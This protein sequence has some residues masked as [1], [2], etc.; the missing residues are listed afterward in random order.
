MNTLFSGRFA[1][2]RL[3]YLVFIGVSVLVRSL[4]LIKSWTLA[5][6]GIVALLK[7]FGMGLVFDI[8]AAAYMSIPLMLYLILLPE[9][10]YRQRWQR[11][12]LYIGFLA[13]FYLLG[14]MA[15][16]EWLFWDE[17]DSRFNFIAVDYLVYTHEVIG[18]IRESYPVVPLL[19]GVAVMALLGLWST[20]KDLVAALAAQSRWR[21]RLKQGG[22][23]ALIPLLALVAVDI[24]LAGVMTNRYNSELA[25][26][27]MYA[28]FAAYRNNELDY[29]RF[30]RSEDD[31]Q[32]T[33]RLQKL[34]QEPG[35][36]VVKGQAL[37]RHVQ[38]SGAEKH[39]NVVLITVES[40]SAEYLGMFGNTD[41]VSPHLDAL[42][43]DSLF[44]TRFYATGTRTVR[45][46]EAITLSLPPTPG[47]SI[48]KRPDNEGMFSLGQVFRDHGYA[49]RFLYGGYGY[50]DNMNYFFGHN[51][52][53]VVDRTDIADENIHFA[54]VWGVADEDLYSRSLEEFDQL[55]AA[56]K[57]FFGLLMTTS[58]HRPYSYPQGRIDIPPF[59][60]RKGAVKYTDYAI[61]QLLEQARTRPWF[62]DT[63]FVVV[64]DHCG[65]S[66]GKTELAVDRYHIP[67]L[68]Y[69]PRHIRPGVVD[70]VASQIDLAPTLLGVLNFSYDSRFFGH[71]ILAMRPEQGR[72]LVGNYQKLG[73]VHD[74]QLTVLSPRDGV[75]AFQVNAQGQVGAVIRPDPGEVADSIAYYQGAS[76]VF[77]RMRVAGQDDH[78]AT[79]IH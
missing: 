49:T 25:K 66:A 61:H 18:N 73:Y 58:N 22:V 14:F 78:P 72:A 40:L 6:T 30:Y 39:L 56:G 51:G 54:N 23:L 32:V 38:H 33:Q 65:K 70:T 57:P 45:G 63:V 16:S 34:L 3:F 1:V 27:G 76:E 74:G 10:L 13:F 75:E 44:F 47:R 31:E 9:T 62:D 15:L 67:L 17:F 21:Q 41:G 24:S 43:K 4:L 42:A 5:D 64:A 20:R 60:G 29:R 48:V 59:S 77:A 53:D 55:H 46:L 12:L 36:S 19:L 8:S 68:M 35:A 7:V 71:D 50:F 2:V 37:T 11:P 79:A 52:F 69:S 26:N 28:F